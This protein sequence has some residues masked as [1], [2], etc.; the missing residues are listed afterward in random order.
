MTRT[1]RIFL[2]SGAE[3]AEHRRE[4]ASFIGDQNKFWV[5]K[6]VFLELVRWEGFLD[7]MSDTQLQDEYNAALAACDLFVMLFRTKVGKYSAEEFD[8]A[9]VI[10]A[11]S[12]C[13]ARASSSRPGST[14]ANWTRTTS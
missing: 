1:V 14:S 10:V 3:L 5:P 11:D 2:A 8:R 12:G 6:G 13:A 7:A 9:E 4:F